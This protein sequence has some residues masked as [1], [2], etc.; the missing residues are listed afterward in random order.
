MYSCT[1]EL[2]IEN[3]NRCIGWAGEA[4][5]EL[6]AYIFW[7]AEYWIARQRTGDSRYLDAVGRILKE[8]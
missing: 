1:P 4:G 6:D 8:S 7:G 5:F 3:Y 2:V